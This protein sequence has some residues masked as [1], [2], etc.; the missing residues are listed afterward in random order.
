MYFHILNGKDMKN[1][2]FCSE[3]LPC[4]AIFQALFFPFTRSENSQAV[5]RLSSDREPIFPK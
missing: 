2:Y 4:I 3:V 1:A 5:A